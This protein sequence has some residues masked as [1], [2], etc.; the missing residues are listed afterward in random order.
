MVK[1]VVGNIR[2]RLEGDVNDAICYVLTKRLTYRLKDA[3][4][5][6][7]A[8][9]AEKRGK[10]ADTSSVDSG[11]VNPAPVNVQQPANPVGAVGLPGSAPNI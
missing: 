1:I 3:Y 2:S 9:K 5:I 10:Y 7:E 6:S 8:V 4:F 11:Q